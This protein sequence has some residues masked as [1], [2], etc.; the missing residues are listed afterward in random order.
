MV[1]DEATSALDPAAEAA[2]YTLLARELPGTTIVSVGHHRALREHHAVA[3]EVANGALSVCP[4]GLLRATAG[5]SA[6]CH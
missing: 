4:R 1:L 2:L 3:W 6:S 5:T